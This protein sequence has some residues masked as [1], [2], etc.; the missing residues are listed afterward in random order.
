MRDTNII[1]PYDKPPWVAAGM[2]TEWVIYLK[3]CQTFRGTISLQLK[4]YSRTKRSHRTFLHYSHYFRSNQYLSEYT[5]FIS[6]ALIEE[7]HT[8]HNLQNRAV[9]M[10]QNTSNKNRPLTASL[11]FWPPVHAA[12]PLPPKPRASAWLLGQPFTSYTPLHSTRPPT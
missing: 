1:K 6:S 8:K 7:L 5:R 4:I 11:A 9:L 10:L 12:S 3:R 2:H